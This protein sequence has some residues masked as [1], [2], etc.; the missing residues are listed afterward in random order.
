MFTIILY[1]LLILLRNGGGARASRF[2]RR[3]LGDPR[4]GHRNCRTW[5]IGRPRLGPWL[6]SGGNLFFRC[7]AVRKH[8]GRRN[9]WLYFRAWRIWNSPL[10]HAWPCRFRRRVR[11]RF[12][13][14]RRRRLCCLLGLP[15]PQR[16]NHDPGTN[17]GRR[18]QKIRH[19]DTA[20]G[21]D[22]RRLRREQRRGQAALALLIGFPEGVEDVRH[23]YGWG[24]CNSLGAD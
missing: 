19:R 23:A 3:G 20:P 16:A 17:Q 18:Q 13:G 10:C 15:R 14:I 9:G 24:S 5:R 1:V 11:R 8:R 2:L 4:R 6:R 7:G 12:E 22:P 21:L